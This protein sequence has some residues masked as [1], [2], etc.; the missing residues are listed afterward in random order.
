MI[1][2]LNLTS[3]LHVLVFIAV[4][5][6]DPECR[7]DQDCPRQLTCMSETCQNP[8]LV[9][10]PCTSSQQ[11]VV[12]DTPASIRSV[13]CICPEGALAGYGGTCEFGNCCLCGHW[14]Y[15]RYNLILL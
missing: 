15:F 4:V 1:G 9:S 11:C 2:S 5:T 12:T 10:N 13:A 7:V 14:D 6:E 3:L 8:C